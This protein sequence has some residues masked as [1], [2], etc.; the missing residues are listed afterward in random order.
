MKKTDIPQDMLELL[1]IT[2]KTCGNKRFRENG[3]KYY[4]LKPTD[5]YTYEMDGEDR[6]EGIRIWRNAVMIGEIVKN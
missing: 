3:Q 4:I 1:A 5:S 2:I 6:P